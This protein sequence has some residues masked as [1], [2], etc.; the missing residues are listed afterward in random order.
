MNR[1]SS[2]H[3]PTSSKP[4]NIRNRRSGKR[5]R[6]WS[7][8]TLLLT[9]VSII[10]SIIWIAS[11]FFFEMHTSKNLV[12]TNNI[13]DVL[14]KSSITSRDPTAF[15][16]MYGS[17]RFH[18]SFDALPL[19]LQDY[20]TWHREQTS[21]HQDSAKYAVLT[22]LPND[23]CGGLSDRLRPLPFFLFIAKY[24]NRVLCIH[25]K[26]N[27][28]LEEF[29][30]P[31]P[32]I[33]IEWRCPSDVN[34]YYDLNFDSQQQPMVP[35]YKFASKT[36]N[37]DPLSFTS[38][39][40][41]DVNKMNERLNDE[42]YITIKTRTRDYS[43]INEANIFVQKHSY[44]ENYPS[45]GDWQYPDMI[46]HIFRVMFEPIPILGKQINATMTKLG[47]VE[48]EFITAHVRTRYPN[49]HLEHL[50][51]SLGYDIN[52]GMKLVGGIKTYVM[53]L[54]SNALECGHMMSPDLKM[55]IVTDHNEA[56]NYAISHDMKINLNNKEVVVRPVGVNRDEEPLH[57][58]GNHANSTA[59]EFYSVFEDLLIMGGSRCVSHGIGSF[60]SFGAGLAGNRCDV[61][62]RAHTGRRLQCPNDKSK[63]MPVSINAE[64]LAFGEKSDGKGKLVFDEAKYFS[65][66]R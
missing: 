55:L 3:T 58:E 44:F 11:F 34:E 42:K 6:K 33:G 43:D 29:L 48:N 22:C 49:R 17:H 41:K 8:S 61:I 15:L 56:T 10:A 60:G 37:V 46:E 40:E 32:N 51:G 53:N 45:I 65:A 35:M 21:H 23:E 1:R 9:L 30:Q 4:Y 36:K 39:F 28:G 12:H 38:T 26:K 64:E 18:S 25:W 47:L 5:V 52:G 50:F 7:S 62:H 66:S 24:T 16:T 31:I 13:K 54:I 2:R 19:W 14:N 27:Y 59:S 57:M 63:I 20:L